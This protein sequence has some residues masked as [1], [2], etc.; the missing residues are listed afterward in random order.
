[1]NYT[2]IEKDSE[3]NGEGFRV[4]LW[5]SGCTIGC[6]GCHNK[7]LWS[8]DNGKVFDLAAKAEIFNY[9][10][11]EYI[12]GLTLSGGH[13]LESKNISSILQLVKEVKEKFPLKTIWLYT[14]LTLTIDDF[15]YEL[16]NIELSL[17]LDYIDVVVDG[18]YI[19][20]LRDITLPY[21]GSTNQR[22]IDVKKTKELGVISLWQQ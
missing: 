16:G 3:S 13:P 5:V 8:F 4:V 21:R 17:L 18:P 1:M 9:L 19:E 12:D 22:L 2:Y 6:K 10:S 7:E 11:K 15:K 14:G 20:S